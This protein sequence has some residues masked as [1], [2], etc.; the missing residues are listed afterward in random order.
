VNCSSHGD[1]GN[2]SPII[3]SHPYNIFNGFENV[4]APAIAELDGQ[5]GA[6]IIHPTSTGLFVYHHDGSTYWQT[7]TVKSHVFFASPAVGNLDA[8]PEPEIVINMN[9]DV[10]VFEQDGT[11]SW[12]LTMPSASASMPVL[13]DLTG[14]GLLDILVYESGSSQVRVYDYGLGSP[15]LDWTTTVTNALSIYG[16]PAVADIDGTA[17]RRSRPRSAISSNGWLHVPTART[18]LPGPPRSIPAIRGVSIADLDGDGEIEIVTGMHSTVG[19]PMPP[20]PMFDLWSAP[21]LDNLRSTRRS[22][23]STA[24]AH[25]K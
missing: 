19:V 9:R 11:L 13:A 6:E 24:M 7:D 8:D 14:D 21:A 10:V 5:P 2:G 1:G 17:R 12:R 22:W 15:T 20:T 25:M 18:A 23:I 4:A 3:W 16:A